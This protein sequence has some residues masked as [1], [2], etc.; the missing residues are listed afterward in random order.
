MAVSLPF[1]LWNEEPAFWSGG[2]ADQNDEGSA[3]AAHATKASNMVRDNC[4]ESKHA[5]EVSETVRGASMATACA[6]RRR[7]GT[8]DRRVRNDLDLG[9]Q[10]SPEFRIEETPQ[11]CLGKASGSGRNKA[12]R[13]LN[14]KAQ[15]RFSYVH[16]WE[17]L[18]FFTYLAESKRLGAQ[19]GPMWSQ[20]VPKVLIR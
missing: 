12:R 17:G 18:I 4:W 13:A 3:L 11:I 14:K 8:E 20:G 10:Q 9:L 6:N 5:C 16:K 19:A 1:L 15:L 2:R 7:E